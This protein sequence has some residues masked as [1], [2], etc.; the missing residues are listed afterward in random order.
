M[1]FNHFFL[2]SI[3]L[4]LLILSKSFEFN[5]VKLDNHLNN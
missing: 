1:I 5:F 4:I 2:L 3:P